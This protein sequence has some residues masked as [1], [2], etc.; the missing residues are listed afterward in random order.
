MVTE[1]MQSLP[2]GIPKLMVSSGA[3]MPQYAGDFFGSSDIT[4][5]S[6]V[7]DI[8]GLHLLSKSVLQRAAGAICGMVET[9][10]G[11]VVT[12][13]KQSEKPLIALT[14]F[15]Y[16]T[17]CCEIVRRKME[18]EGYTVIPC[19]ANG[20]GD[21][22]M[23]RLIAE[24]IFNGVIDIV[25]GGVSEQIV[26]GNRAAGSV[27]LE[28]AGQQGLPQV[29]TPCGFE[30]ISCGPISRKDTN[31]PLWISRNIAERKYYIQDAY[32]VQA[33]TT[34]EEMETI[35]KVV[36]DKLN[37]SM[38]PITFLVPLKGWSSLSEKG[39]PLYDKNA[40]AFFIEK[41]RNTLKPEID[42]IELNFPLNSNEFADAIVEAFTKMI[43]T[44]KAV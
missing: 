16:S 15:Q 34:K 37:K 9:S 42:I 40:D 27:R 32:R 19:H 43:D 44:R 18:E 8:D 4:I 1:V 33:R 28:S 3:A 35:A 24:D 14:Q 12:T 2:Y 23:E 10:M 25:P 30:M 20:I 11:S 22:A 36:S 7:V 41:L 38:G 21:K 26:G 39:Q 29:I 31:D 13:L 17:E 5:F 6:S